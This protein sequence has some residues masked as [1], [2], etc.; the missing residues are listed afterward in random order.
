MVPFRSNGALRCISHRS[1]LHVAHYP[2][3][4]LVAF[5]S[6]M[7]A[8]IAQLHSQTAAE[9]N[10]PGTMQQQT[11]TNFTSHSTRSPLQCPQA[12]SPHHPSGNREAPSATL[13]EYG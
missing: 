13:M 6:G 5:R 8:S 9:P 11:P 7:V 12:G 3:P 1:A 10:L 4:V 2:Y